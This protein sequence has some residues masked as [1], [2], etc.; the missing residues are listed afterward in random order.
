MTHRSQ[1]NCGREP[2]SR[3]A[4]RAPR[5]SRSELLLLTDRCI[6][7][8]HYFSGGEALL[9]LRRL[10]RTPTATPP[11]PSAT[12]STPPSPPAPSPSGALT[13]L[14]PGG[15][16][17]DCTSSSPSLAR[18]VAAAAR[19]AGCYAV[20]SRVSG[21]DVG[22]RDGTL[23]ILAGG[24]EAMAAWLAPLFAH[25]GRPTYMG[26]PGSGQSSKIANQ[27]AVAGA[28]VGTTEAL[29]FANAAINMHD[30]TRGALCLVDLA[31]SGRLTTTGAIGNTLVEAVAINQS[32][33]TLKR[34]LSS[35]AT[36]AVHVP[37][38]DSKLTM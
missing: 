33:T 32:L 25:L 30:H 19:A 16:L 15:V 34:V 10:P 14:R 4:S 22:A 38:M 8:S 31:G 26:P 5:G 20:D 24:D 35:V 28:L 1:V 12:G 2:S 3:T 11:P 23:A 9:P 37:V 21:G 7:R 36:R 17:V 29:E 27:I 13:G 18:E 6:G